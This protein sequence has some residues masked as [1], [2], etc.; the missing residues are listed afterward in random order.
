MLSTVGFLEGILDT[1]V[2]VESYL[3]SKIVGVSGIIA[4][5]NLVWTARVFALSLQRGLRV[6]FPDSNGS[7]PI[8]SNL[9]TFAIVFAALVYA[10]TFILSS[11]FST[12]VRG[13][14]TAGFLGSLL[15][16]GILTLTKFL[17]V[18]GLGLLAFFTYRFVPAV[19]PKQKAAFAGAALCIVCYLVVS[20][21]FG[22]MLDPTKYNLLYGALGG[23]I[24][25]LANV[26]FFF[27]F[28]FL[29]AQLA[30]VVDSY[31]ALVF[32]RFRKMAANKKAGSSVLER[33]LFSNPEGPL[34]KFLRNFEDGEVLFTRGEK[35][36]DIFYVI[37]GSI[38][39]YLDQGEKK[40]EQ[41]VATL[42]AGS[43]IG[44]IAYLL[45]E[46]RTATAKAEGSAV[47]LVLPPPLFDE[48]LKSDSEAARHVIGAL[49]QRL[50]T[51]NESLKTSSQGSR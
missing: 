35:D 13:A 34:K 11:W 17:P 12:Y 9:M 18:F 19:P 48:V 21:I 41:K 25:L 33:R 50:K 47:V 10:L 51:T 16:T 31:D 45:S 28:F 32:S 24:I 44:E 1:R 2:V 26:Y 37:S 4:V 8:R 23:L 46:A 6:V 42:G 15:Q 14:P 38:A 36:Q 5:F 22:A 7:N 40:T 20:T 49:S 29:G 27:T 30:F 39:I 3:S 43:F